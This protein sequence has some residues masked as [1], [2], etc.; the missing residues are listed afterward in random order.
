MA[1]KDPLG[2]E[3]QGGGSDWA[4]RFSQI[5]Q[6]WFQPL[7]LQAGNRPVAARGH[8]VVDT[9]GAWWFFTANHD[10]FSPNPTSPKNTRTESPVFA[11]EGHLSYDVKPRLW[12]SLDGNFWAGGRT[13]LNGVENSS[14]TQRNSRLGGTVSIPV[15]QHNALKLS[16]SRGAYIRFGGNYDTVSVAWQ[17]SWQGRPN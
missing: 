3:H 15:S 17:Y 4:I 12:A 16:Y 11:F 13:S 14:T 9:Y 5:D 7:G 10:F 8:W 6:L 1:A 2:R